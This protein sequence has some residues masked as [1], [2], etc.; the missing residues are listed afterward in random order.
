M[1]GKLTVPAVPASS[2]GTDRAAFD[3]ALRHNMALLTGQLGGRLGELPAT[4]TLDDVIARLN[5]L[6]RLLQ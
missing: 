5:E 4:A 2:S 3:Q 6:V 1:A